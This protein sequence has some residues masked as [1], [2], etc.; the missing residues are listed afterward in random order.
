M[1][2]GTDDRQAKS[3]AANDRRPRWACEPI[4]RGQPAEGFEESRDL[5]SGNDRTGVLN[6]K[7]RSIVP[8]VRLNSNPAAVGH[9]VLDAV[10]DKVLDQ[11]LEQKGITQDD[12]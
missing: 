12:A 10:L 6:D 11:P 3:C 9:V 2:D 5:V 7:F 8:G 4:G 1:G